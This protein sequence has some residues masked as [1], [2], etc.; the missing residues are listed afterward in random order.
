MFVCVLTVAV[1][2]APQNRQTNS[3][4][5]TH[6]LL[7]FSN[8]YKF[9]DGASKQSMLKLSE[10]ATLE[11]VEHQGWNGSEFTSYH[12]KDYIYQGG[13]RTE[14]HQYYKWEV[15]ADW[16]IDSREV[17]EFVDDRLLSATNQ[18]YI[19]GGFVN[20][21]RTLFFYQMIGDYLYLGE[22][23]DQFWDEEVSDWV[24]DERTEFT[25][26][27][28]ELTGGESSF[29]DVNQ[30]K[31]Y[32]RFL[33]E[34][35]GNDLYITYQ[36]WNGAAW[37]NTEREIIENFSIVEMYLLFVE[38]LNII[39]TESYLAIAE[40]FPDYTEQSWGVNGWT[41]VSRQK[42]ETE[43]IWETGQIA[44]KIIAGQTFDGEWK[45][46]TELRISYENGKPLEMVLFIAEEAGTTE[47]I[48]NFGEEFKYNEE[49]QLRY[50][51]QKEAA[52]EIAKA[53]GSISTELVIV[54]R[55][56]L[57]W[58]GTSTSIGDDVNPVAF[59]LG[60]SYPNPFNP[61][62]VIPFQL[63][64][65]GDISIRVFDMLGR[66]VI[67]LANGSYP[68]GNHSVRFDASGL[69]SGI[70]LI[71]MDAPGFQQTS[72]VTLLK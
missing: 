24:N 48:P 41:D 38:E 18:I 65:S 58:S 32:E 50:V 17:Y 16:E 36:E 7:E 9:A 63:G 31:I 62:T 55:L 3:H 30:W 12:K 46:F 67:T 10:S 21:Y 70:Y 69:S 45:P 5:V 14:T 52:G 23:I 60:N 72:R 39:D 54:G 1:V 47:L 13:N 40:L 43:Y 64:S 56:I 59:R 8:K 26:A 51:I 42:T 29:W 4:R 34:E 22:T 68:A 27:E 11:S 19:D 66:D 2:G 44:N 15:G 33:L 49:G 61:A 53:S 37:N 35:Q 57:D 25:S 28:G 6:P 20:D 71:R